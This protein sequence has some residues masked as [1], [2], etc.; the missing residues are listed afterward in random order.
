MVQVLEFLAGAAAGATLVWVVVRGKV[1]AASEKAK[2]EAEAERAVLA[3][4]LQNKDRELQALSTKADHAATLQRE[5]TVLKLSEAELKIILDNERNAAQEKLA[6][7]NQAQQKLGDA[8]KA[9]SAEARRSNNQ[10]F[11]DLA[12]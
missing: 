5:V 4:R 8:F 9:L 11:L 6:L 3:E 12:K 10:S 7:L 1:R 2:A